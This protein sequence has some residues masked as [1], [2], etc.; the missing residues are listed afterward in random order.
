MGVD[1]HAYFGYGIVVPLDEFVEVFPDSFEYDDEDY[2]R[3]ECIGI[4]E[5]ETESLKFVFMTQCREPTVF[6]TTQSVA[7]YYFD[8]GDVTSSHYHGKSVDLKQLMLDSLSIDPWLEEYF[9]S[10]P[11]G[12]MM[13]G[14]AGKKKHYRYDVF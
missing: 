4:E 10:Y 12:Y 11:R 7:Q 5:M 9:P 8:H 13:Y 6:I 14:T 2:G 1:Q 3:W